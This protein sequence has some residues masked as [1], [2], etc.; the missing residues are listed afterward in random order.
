MDDVLFPSTEYEQLF[1]VADERATEND[2][3]DAENYGDIFR[4]KGAEEA[5]LFKKMEIESFCTM[6][7]QRIGN[8]GIQSSS[9]CTD[10]VAV[11]PVVT[12]CVL[13]AS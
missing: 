7:V 1:S 11:L 9:C 12:W 6:I 10:W 13:R 3:F 2:I 8:R 5:L 4:I